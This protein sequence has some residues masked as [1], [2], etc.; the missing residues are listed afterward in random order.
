MAYKIFDTHAHYNEKIYDDDRESLFES[1][2]AAGV[3]RFCNIAVDLESSRIND[4]YTKE[5]DFIYGTVGVFPSDV[6]EA[7]IKW[8]WK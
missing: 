5:Y 8:N 4:R 6:E 3:E 1:M 7:G 2:R